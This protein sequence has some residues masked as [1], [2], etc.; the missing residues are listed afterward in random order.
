MAVQRQVFQIDTDTGTQ[1]DTGPAFW[2]A[3]LNLAWKPTTIDTGA[4]LQI[5]L[6]PRKG[7]TGDGYL[8]YNNNDVLGTQFHVVVRADINVD[9][10]GG[11]DTGNAPI[12]AAGDHFRVKVIPGGAACAGTLWLYTG[13]V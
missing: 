3:W 11:V 7:D 6:Y 2:G 4:D 12:V 10:Q 5:G 8:V 1:G 9:G 13:D